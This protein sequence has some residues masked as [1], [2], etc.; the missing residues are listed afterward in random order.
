VTLPDLTS[1]TMAPLVKVTLSWPALAN[2]AS[3]NVYRT[4]APGQGVT[5]VQFIAN[6]Q[7]AGAMVTFNDTGLPTT[8]QT[9][10]PIGSLGKWNPVSNLTVPRYGAAAAIAHGK[11]TATTDTWFLYAAGGA[12]D[13]ALTQA[14]LLDT[15]E[16]A[17]VDISVADGTQTVSPFTVGKSGTA[18]ASIGGGRA[19]LSA[20]SADTT[21]KAEIPVGNTYVYFGTGMDRPLTALTTKAAMVAGLVSPASTSGD[22]G[23]LATIPAAQA[24]GAGAATI[25]GFLFTVGGWNSGLSV[26]NTFSTTFCPTTGCIAQPPTLTTWNNGGGGTPLIPRVLLSA[27]V[28]APFLYIFGG[29]TNTTAS[30]A[31]ASTERTVW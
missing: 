8:A 27:V 24:G 25:A 17:Q 14:G 31:T 18:N 30:N 16:W 7:G 3:Y 11:T 20:Y 19:F 2:V 4:S 5:Q 15:Y 9:P 10:L 6:V 13:T 12:G 28:E 23:T 21:I 29:S 22:L 26:Q 1:M